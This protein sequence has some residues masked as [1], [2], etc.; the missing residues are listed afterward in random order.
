MLS[1]WELPMCTFL[2]LEQLVDYIFDLQL[3]FLL[4][5]LF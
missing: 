3:K 5:M 4:W 2:Q 1:A